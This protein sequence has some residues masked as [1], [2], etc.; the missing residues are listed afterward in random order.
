[1]ADGQ[2][3]FEQRGVEFPRTWSQP[4]T[5][6]VDQKYL[7]G[8]LRTAQRDDTQRTM[9][10]RVAD[11]IYGWGKADGYFKSD[12]DAWAFRDELVHLLLHQ[13]MAVNSPVW[14]NVGVE[15]H[16]QCSACF[17]NS[18]DDSMSSILGLAKTEGM[19]FKYGSGTGSNPSSARSSARAPH[20][21]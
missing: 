7:R 5:N 12:A 10:G 16:P 6:V 19:L 11:T 14:F 4:A 1:G 2:V 17:I 18:V 15:S 20:R 13:K 8:T 9:I 21:W 3:F